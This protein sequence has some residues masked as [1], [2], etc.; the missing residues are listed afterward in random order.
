MGQFKI[1]E[2]NK[3]HPFLL[4]QSDWPRN[5]NAIFHVVSLLL[6]SS[7]IQFVFIRHPTFANI[8]SNDCPKKILYVCQ[9]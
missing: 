1:R 9:V 4:L 2:V 8:L 6:V 5:M 3:L 7:V